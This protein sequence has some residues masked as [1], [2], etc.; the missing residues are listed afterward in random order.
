MSVMD[1]KKV[2]VTETSGLR[3]TRAIPPSLGPVVAD[4]ELDAPV[5]LTIDHLSAILTR[6]GVRTA[7]KVVARRLREL[8]W[9]LPTA[10]SGVWE[11]APGSHAGPL[12]HGDPYLELRAA[13]A[14][15]PTLPAAVCL[16]SALFAHRLVDRAPER[17]EVAVPTSSH[18]PEGLR[19]GARVVRFDAN[20]D[21]QRIAEVPVH[22]PAT[23][24]AHLASRP[25]DVGGW[26]AIAEVLP[27]LVADA[28]ADEI[29]AELAGR[30]FA[31]RARLAY[32]VQGVAP[33]L[34][35][36][37]LP[38]SEGGRNAP[39]VWFGPHGKV[40]RFSSRYSIADTLLPFDPAELRAQP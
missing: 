3:P 1:S 37:L 25:N 38:P 19:R 13:L 5:V 8:G 7:P 11:F 6:A 15:R 32:L 35:D 9:L 31:T 12:R 23:V 21:P 29:R 20:L 26:G 34:A 17:L 10:T 28:A 2:S 33:D 24:L 36:K 16:T 39:R 40:K 18:V 22:R 4:L 27:D 30:P 14:A